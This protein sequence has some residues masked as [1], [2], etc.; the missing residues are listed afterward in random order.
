[1]SVREV[2]RQRAGRPAVAHKG[3]VV[4]RQAMAVTVCV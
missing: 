3:D 4:G 1:M 2:Q